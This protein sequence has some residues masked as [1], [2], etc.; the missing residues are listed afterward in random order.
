MTHEA[1]L[2][3]WPAP[4]HGDVKE[5][6]LSTSFKI[7]YLQSMYLHS[8]GLDFTLTNMPFFLRK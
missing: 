3:S 7:I 5:T 8:N 6:Y 1:G 4:P 2:P